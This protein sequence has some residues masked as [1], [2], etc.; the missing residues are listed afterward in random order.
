MLIAD[1][2]LARITDR[3]PPWFRKQVQTRSLLLLP[4]TLG[5]K[6]AGLI[7]GDTPANRP[8]VLSEKE[9]GLV[10]TLRDKVQLAFRPPR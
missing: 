2:G 7:Y 8:L 1:T 5:D 10:R 3:L 6:P 4:I 9:L